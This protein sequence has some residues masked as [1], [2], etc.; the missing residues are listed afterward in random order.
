VK[1]TGGDVE[2][3]IAAVVPGKRR[4]DAQTLVALLGDVTGSEPALWGTIIGFG[5]CHYRY[6]TGT[7]GDT[8]LAAFAPRKAASTIYLLEGAGPHADDLGRLGPHTFTKGCLYL[9][10]LAAVDLAALRRILERS[11]SIALE[12]GIPGVT[13]EVR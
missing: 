13:L 12:D 3:F 11:H 10:D 9:K 6:P 8:P 5:T 7:E 2:E 1:P 4:R